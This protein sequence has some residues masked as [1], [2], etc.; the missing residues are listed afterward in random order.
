MVVSGSSLLEHRRVVYTTYNNLN[1]WFNKLKQF[2]ISKGF[3]RECKDNKDGDSE[4]VFFPG[5]LNQIIN[6][7]ESALTLNGNQTK[8]GGRSFTNPAVPEGADHTNKSS[9]LITFIGGS[10]A[11]GYLLPP[12]FQL[13]SVATD[14]YKCIQTEILYSLPLV[15]G[16]YGTN[17]KVDNGPTVNCNACA[18]MDLMKF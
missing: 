18:G 12:H 15:N 10:S 17:N 14:E 4:L 8:S 13:K 2:L 7:D 3:V 6:L 9:T 5:Q 1:I 11:T 16:V